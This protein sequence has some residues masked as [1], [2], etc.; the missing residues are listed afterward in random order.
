MILSHRVPELTSL[1]L[2]LAVARLGSLGKAAREIGIT[3]PAASFRIRTM[4]KQ[5]GFA[6]IERSPNGSRLTAAG[7]LVAGWAR[8]VVTCAE[9]LDA[10]IET[11]R[12]QRDQQLRVAASLTIAEYLLPNWLAAL[13]QQR[14]RISI[15]LTAG[16]SQLAASQVLKGEADLG[17]IESISVP[18]GLD[19][20]VIALDSLVVVTSPD[21]HWARL[22]EGV[23]AEELARTPL[24]MREQGSGTRQFLARALAPYGGPGTAL[25][26]LP[27]ATAVRAAVLAG[28]G[29]AVMSSL[30][31]KEDL[32]ARRLVSVPLQGARLSR[33]LRAA[34]PAGQR[35]LGPSRDLLSLTRRH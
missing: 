10:G 5:I 16:N 31:V 1:E 27:S 13:R 17:F 12:L 32:Q 28:A 2:L 22:S 29:A 11:L 25:L 4:E 33:P 7:A 20:I 15:S 35:P 9:S 19:T 34:W 8:Q 3:Q 24:I 23:T 30:A 14:P 26:E 21:H 18:A 6:L